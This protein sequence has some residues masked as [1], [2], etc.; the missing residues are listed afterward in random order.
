MVTPGGPGRAGVQISE[1]SRLLSYVV[2][3]PQEVVDELDLGETETVDIVRATINFLLERDPPTAIMKEFSID[4]VPRFF[5]EFY[6]ELTA[7]LKG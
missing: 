7:R 1:G 2:T 5:P 4:V 3:V 6:E